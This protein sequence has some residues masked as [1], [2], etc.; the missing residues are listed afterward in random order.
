MGYEVA[1]EWHPWF[2]S[3]SNSVRKQVGGYATRY[4]TPYNFTFLTIKGGRHEVPETAPA[5]AFD[6][7]NRLL[8][9]TSF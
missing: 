1:H 2:Y 7:L 9:G 3:S 4:A 6:M 8:S 5:A